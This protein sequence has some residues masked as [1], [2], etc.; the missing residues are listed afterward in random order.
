MAATFSD[1]GSIKYSYE[2]RK[3]IDLMSLFLTGLDYA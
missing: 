3:K 2:G 1:D